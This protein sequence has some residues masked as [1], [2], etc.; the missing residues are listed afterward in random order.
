MSPTPPEVMPE[1]SEARQHDAL[2]IDLEPVGARVQIPRD[3]TLL[4]AAQA[5]G[6]ELAAVCGGVGLCGKCRVR[7]MTGQ[8]AAPTE[9]ESEFLAPEEIARGDRLACQCRP[10][11]DIKVDVPPE[12]LMTAQRL[13]VEGLEEKIDLDP[14]VVSRKVALPEPDLR[15]LRSDT[16]RL[17]A[18]LQDSTPSVSTAGSTLRIGLPILAQLSPQL[19]AQKWAA[20]VV[21]RDGEIAGILA[22]DAHPLGLAVDIGTTKMAAYLVDLENGTTLAKGGVTNPQVSYG[23][24][25]LSRIAYAN[26]HQDGRVALQKVVV[27]RLNQIVDDL[28]ARASDGGQSASPRQIVEAVLVGNTAMHHLAARLPVRQLGFVPYV[29]AVAEPMSFSAHDIGLKLAPGCSVYLPPNIAGFVGADHVSMLV[30]TQAWKRKD[31]V[32]AID[33]GT[34]TEISLVS[35]G[36]LLACS[37]ASGPAFEGAHIRDGMRAV[38]GAI[39]KIKI[40]DSSIFAQTVDGLP[41]VGICGSGILDAIAEM[42]QRQILDRSGRMYCYEPGPDVDQYCNEFVLVPANETG[43]GREIAVTLA[44]V[45]EIQLAKGAIRAGI[46]ILLKEA[47]LSA[48]DIDEFVVAGAFGTYLDLESAMRIGMFP[49]LP[50]DRFKQVGNAAGMGAKLMLTSRAKRR[51]AAEIVD[52]VEYVELTTHPGFTRVFAHALRF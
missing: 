49:E 12:S 23:E 9:A 30:A 14:V 39:E 34:N 11:T 3:Q 25:V 47:D 10:M 42:Y 27:E 15:D 24:D 52:R 48:L 28:C 44:D 45:R 6:V 1:Q 43:H 13:Q 50:L 38:P 29:P 31:E 26:E 7:L 19:R 35:G 51:E 32:I 46:E 41:P 40:L 22:P 37:C 18:A 4:D 8:A 36:R 5:A 21:L 20:T 2:Q 17:L 16:T 33:I